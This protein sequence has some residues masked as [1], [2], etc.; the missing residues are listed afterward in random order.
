MS[1]SAKNFP[2]IS[3]SEYL[4][5]ARDVLY[6]HEFANGLV[7][8][9]AGASREHH[10]I[11]GDIFVLLMAGV[12]PPCIVFQSDMKVNIKAHDSEH[13][14]DPDTYVMCSD[15]DRHK[16]FNKRPVLVVEV[17]S[18]SSNQYDRG[19]KFATYRK[20]PSLE[21]YVIIQQTSPSVEVF[22]KRTHGRGKNTGL[23]TKSRLRA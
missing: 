13:F 18:E 15:L 5:I 6:R 3:A 9:M 1:D 14:Y 22:R 21:E 19:E 12:K 4:Q 11:S 10:L 16:R 2:R 8:P 17:A 23:Q 20:L 7:Y